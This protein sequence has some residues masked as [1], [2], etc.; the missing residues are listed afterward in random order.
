MNAMG[1]GTSGGFFTIGETGN[2][3]IG[4]RQ[5]VMSAVTVAEQDGRMRRNPRQAPNESVVPDPPAPSAPGYSGSSVIT[6]SI[7]MPIARAWVAGTMQVNM[8]IAS[9][10]FMPENGE[11]VPPNKPRGTGSG[12]PHPAAGRAAEETRRGEAP[13]MG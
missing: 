13:G 10:K 1:L 3:F 7:T 12:A 5:T 6:A 11:P 8:P 2:G 4:R 9:R